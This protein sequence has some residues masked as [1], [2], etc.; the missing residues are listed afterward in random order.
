MR[1]TKDHKAETRARIVKNAAVQLREK[2]AQGIGVADLMKE[3]GLTHGGF[4]AHFKSREAL[5]I[6]ALSYAMDR[7]RERW[8][9]VVDRTPEDDRFEA[10]IRY[11][12]TPQHRDNPGH[13]CTM[14]TLASEAT[15]EGPKAR[16]M[17][18]GQLERMID[19]LAAQ[20]PGPAK[21]AREQAIAAL[22][23][24]MGTMLMS[25]VAGS[26]DLSAQILDIGRDAALAQAP[27]KKP[28]RKASP[29]TKTKA[30]TA[31]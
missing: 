11:Y 23:T 26:G 5:M 30:K 14:A 28:V 22:A 6:E 20:L 1:Y 29:K 3:A 16:K 4:Y 19:T 8:K 24:M 17:F 2:G 9:D 7:S 18:L 10:L 27:A 31:N 12:I 13:G 15:R 21:A 25:R